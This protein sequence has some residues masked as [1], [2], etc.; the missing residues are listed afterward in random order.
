MKERLTRKPRTS[1]RGIGPGTTVARVAAL[2]CTCALAILCAAT[3]TASASPAARADARGA[4]TSTQASPTVDVVAVVITPFLTWNDITAEKAPE[5]CSLAIRGAIGNMNSI[6]T[7]PGH[8]TATGGALTLS[9]G[10]WTSGPTSGAA[11]PDDILAIRAANAGSLNPPDIGALGA[12]LH[13]AGLKTAALGD[14]D[15]DTSTAA[16]V[17]RPAALVAMDRD[18]AVDFDTTG[19]WLLKDDPNAPFGVRNDRARLAAAVYGALAAG[20]SLIVVDPGDLERAHDDTRQ[21]SA[22][23]VLSHAEA[24]KSTSEV[25][26]DVAAALKGRRALLLIVTPATSKP[27]YQPPYFG[28]TIAVGDGF[29]GDLTSQSTHRIGLVTN[30]DFAPTVLSALSLEPTA[31]MLGVPM[32]STPY[33]SAGGSLGS[34]AFQEHVATLAKLG[35]SVGAIDYS[36]DLLFLTPF[37][38]LVI[39]LVAFV[40]AIALVP[41]LRRL[42]S[43]GRA[44]ILL[45]LAIPPGA[46]LMFALVPHPTSPPQ[47]MLLFGGSTLATF[48]VVGGI[49]AARKTRPEVPLLAL[50]TLT[51]LLICADQW[52]GHPIESGLFSYSIR[53]G[54]RYYGMGNEGAAL[55]VGASMIAVG[56]VCDFAEKSRWNRLVRVALMPVVGAVVLVTT[57][58]AFAGANVGVAIWGVIAY[59]VAWAG[60]Q[61]VKFGWK[62]AAVIAAVIVVAVGAA[63]AVDVARGSHETHLGRFFAQIMQG[64]FSTV[65]TLVLRKAMNNYNY[66]MQTPYTLVAL[67]LAAGLAALRWIGDRPLLR[68]LS[69]RP[70]IS[71]TLIGLLIGSIAATL[72]EDSGVVMPALMLFAGALPVFSLAL[73]GGPGKQP[74]SAPPNHPAEESLDPN[75]T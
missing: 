23:A 26:G 35:T 44:L 58:A 30:L 57:G 31:T 29:V 68:V 62:S 63:V 25:I 59:G 37:A 3:A 20:S 69:D 47:V 10:R 6:T 9:A 54:W 4:T 24:V 22:Q 14:G 40:T 70:G 36:R 28:P 60:L 45:A 65:G 18:G 71:A 51:S 67:A 41:S 64:D 39:V 19:P 66:I 32:G 13:A 34:A 61:R 43:W 74:E 55:L 46:W 12:V 53:A 21:S 15:E 49:S 48:A 11:A 17:K 50:S 75:V 5:L 16:G 42:R 38:V 33:T 8:P 52:S 27:Y 2:I 56:F 7:D 72:T 1:V 73:L